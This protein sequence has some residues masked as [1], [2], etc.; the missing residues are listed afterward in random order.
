M[1]REDWSYKNI[2]NFYDRVRMSLNATSQ[3]TVPDEY[4][5]YPEKAPFAESTIKTRVP[6]WSELD[7]NKFAI[8]ESIIVYQTASLFQNLVVSKSVKKKQ[9]PTITLEYNESTSF[10]SAGMSLSDIIDLLVSELNGDNAGSNFF[11]FLVTKGGFRY[12]KI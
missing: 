9:I 4:I 3:T 7:D 12:G 11:G 2:D 8:F 1:A 10:G 5:D 6:M